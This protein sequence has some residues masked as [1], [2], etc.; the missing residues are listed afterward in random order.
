MLPA[1]K[2][3]NRL[4]VIDLKCIFAVEMSLRFAVKEMRAVLCKQ[5][6]HG[7]K[8]LQLIAAYTTTSRPLSAKRVYLW[9]LGTTFLH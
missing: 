9:V 4:S 8:P 3:K 1:K 5:I 2:Q 6:E 7:N